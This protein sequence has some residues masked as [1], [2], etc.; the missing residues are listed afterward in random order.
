LIKLD[1][2]FMKKWCKICCCFFVY[3]SKI[4]IS[5]IDI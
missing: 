1:L 4:K 3:D 2:N 5:T